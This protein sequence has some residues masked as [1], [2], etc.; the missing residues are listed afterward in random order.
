MR[1][2]VMNPDN[3]NIG[4]NVNVNAN[5]NENM[6]AINHPEEPIVQFGV[7]QVPEGQENDINENPQ[8]REENIGREIQIAELVGIAGNPRTVVYSV[9]IFLIAIALSIGALVWTPFTIGR[10][11]RSVFGGYIHTAYQKANHL[12][13]LM[14][15]YMII[16]IGVHTNETKS[17]MLETVVE[18]LTNQRGEYFLNVGIGYLFAG[19][20]TLVFSR[21]QRTQR[22]LNR[23][24][25]AVLLS[26]ETGINLVLKMNKL[27]MFLVIE[28]LIFPY[29]C[30][31]LISFCTVPLFNIAET[32]A[33]RV[34]FMDES[35][36]SSQLVHW[37][38]GIVIPCTM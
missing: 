15:D 13:D 18:K 21:T 27:V 38:V 12:T 22:G 33:S 30:G 2:V 9:L 8:Q 25:N 1:E 24:I 14:V 23:L 37:L 10:I 17:D 7:I 6:D 29:F 11:A 5:L 3:L 28:I 16:S 35:P 36:H 20:L 34:K 26:I 19:A 32:A 31:Y 4:I